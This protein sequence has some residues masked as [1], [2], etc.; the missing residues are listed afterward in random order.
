M[1]R[2]SK[3]DMQIDL[4]RSAGTRNQRQTKREL[5]SKANGHRKPADETLDLQVLLEA[6][7]SVRVDGIA[8]ASYM[9]SEFSRINVLVDA[10]G[11]QDV[12]DRLNRGET[13]D[14]A[15]YYFRATPYFETGSEKLAWINGICCIATGARQASGPT[16]HVFQVL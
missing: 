15:T 5:S 11:P 10:T 7:Q 14:P 4:K 3:A 12:I 16:Y 6:L 1:P 2:T 9:G 13:V 8:Q